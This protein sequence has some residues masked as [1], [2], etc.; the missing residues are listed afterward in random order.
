M[1]TP[2]LGELPRQLAEDFAGSLAQV[3]RTLGLSKFE[4]QDPTQVALAADDAG[5]IWPIRVVQ[6]HPYVGGGALKVGLQPQRQEFDGDPGGAV[7]D[8]ISV[9]AP[10]IDP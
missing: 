6:R 8:F 2:L 7:A 5:R 9:M 10:G 3:F 1:K 4:D